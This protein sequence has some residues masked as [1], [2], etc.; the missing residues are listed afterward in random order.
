MDRQL[1]LDLTLDRAK[2]ASREEWD[3]FYATPGARTDRK[4]SETSAVRVFRRKDIHIELGYAALEGAGIRLKA[5]LRAGILFAA[6]PE[7]VIGLKVIAG[8]GVRRRHIGR[9]QSR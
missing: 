5:Q 4:V 7:S 9:I 1:T 2:Q 3:Q 6:M 8:I